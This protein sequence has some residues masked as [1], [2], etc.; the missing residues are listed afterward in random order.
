VRTQPFDVFSGFPALDFHF[1]LVGL[2][3]GREGF[4][5]ENGPVFCPGGESPMVRKVLSQPF[6][7][8]LPGMAHVEHVQ[9]R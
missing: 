4:R 9:G 8:Q 3:F 2:V 5:M 6:L 1:P 7:E